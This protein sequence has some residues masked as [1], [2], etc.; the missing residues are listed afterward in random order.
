[1]TEGVKLLLYFILSIAISAVFAPFVI[2]LMTKLKAKQT[3][4][5]YVTQHQY[6]TG[7]PTMGGFIFLLP[8]FI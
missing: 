1:M 3:V 2:K 8:A 6:K 7:T 4:L 5:G